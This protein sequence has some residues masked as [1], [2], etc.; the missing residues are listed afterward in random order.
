MVA[1]ASSRSA[2]GSLPQARRV[3]RQGKFEVVGRHNNDGGPGTFRRPARSLNGACSFGLQGP[4]KYI[5]A[6]VTAKR[7]DFRLGSARPARNR[8]AI[9]PL[10]LN[11]SLYETVPRQR[12]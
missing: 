5:S 11:L 1:V 7:L 6:A 10:P 9:S 4:S 2:D 3:A 12:H 8:K